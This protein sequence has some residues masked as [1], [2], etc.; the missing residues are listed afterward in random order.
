MSAT[1]ILESYD[2]Q[3]DYSGDFDVAM[4]T[5]GSS[6]DA[7][8]YQ[9]ETIMDQDA[10]HDS[11]STGAGD[12]ESVEVEM[13]ET[14][15]DHADNESIE[16]EMADE[17]EIYQHEAGDLLDVE[18][19]DASQ[20]HS[21]V[22]MPA[23]I[24][25]PQMASG[26]LV[27]FTIHSAIAFTDPRDS[28]E[29]S[30]V[31][32]DETHLHELSAS[33][34][35][36]ETIS[37]SSPRFG[38]H[39]ALPDVGEAAESH[40]DSAVDSSTATQANTD[41]LPHTALETEAVVEVNEFSN[42]RATPVGDSS[43]AQ[44]EETELVHI[45]P[46]A[47]DH[48]AAA[49]L[50]QPTGAERSEPEEY[51]DEAQHYYEYNDATAN[52]PDPHEISE[53]VYI[54]P[55]PAVLLSL[56]STDQ[57]AVCL[58]NQPPTRA[59]SLGPS[60]GTHPPEQQVLT[61]LLHHR[62]TLYYEP[63]VN[64]FEALRQEEYI[65]RIPESAEGE[66][67]L[68]AYDLQLI[69]SED[70]AHAREITLHDLNVLHDGSDLSGPLRL[71][72]HLTVPRFIIRYHMLRDQVARL[73]LA[74]EEGEEGEQAIAQHEHRD[75]HAEEYRDPEEYNNP[76][77]NPEEN[78]ES[79]QPD[80]QYHEHSEDHAERLTDRQ[81]TGDI[82]NLTA[83]DQVYG[84]EAQALG[85][86]SAFVDANADADTES[87]LYQEDTGENFNADAVHDNDLSDSVTAA[88][89]GEPT[90]YED[91]TEAKA[92]DEHYS[93]AFPEQEGS[94]NQALDYH[95]AQ[96]EESTDAD[97]AQDTL[98]EPDV[99]QAT[100]TVDLTEPIGDQPTT[101]GNSEENLEVVNKINAEV[102][103]HD[104]LGELHLPIVCDEADMLLD[105][106]SVGA[107]TK[108]TVYSVDE[109]DSNVVAILE[110]EADL[111]G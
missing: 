47:Q 105:H 10:H 97:N 65:T 67:A 17:E 7:W 57:P 75:E 93:E 72:L 46:H 39:E 77:E 55:P 92:D 4:L 82:S 41:H 99:V 54:D 94:N 83:E 31:P 14:Y 91:Y 52:A 30:T 6:A 98:T 29:T 53:G 109:S 19:Y 1:T 100:Q 79:Q 102:I 27:D 42:S 2:T 18:V 63:L 110:R 62:P 73:N 48:E 37:Y 87:N 68:D 103:F 84:D 49:Q 56:P 108:H 104:E 95:V 34:L 40:T 20:L 58:F 32:Q 107:V 12:R 51:H 90:E 80:Q 69:I 96:D 74:A 13:E 26:E 60:E 50:G 106:D 9:S 33:E 85:D 61:L 66:L 24:D 28:V 71:Q 86:E 88:A 5:A 78:N 15:P 16:Y 21:P 3:M 43:H 25:T 81:A 45:W 111:T 101:E 8:L 11:Q 36:L 59:E 22:P 23:T 44:G 38:V 89:P 70:N 35:P 76:E 64:V